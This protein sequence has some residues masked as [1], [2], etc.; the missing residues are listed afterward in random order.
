MPRPAGSGLYLEQARPQN[1]KTFAGSGKGL[2]RNVWFV[3]STTGD[4]SR[5]DGRAVVAVSL[6]KLLPFG[7]CPGSCTRT[8]KLY[9]PLHETQYG[10]FSWPLRLVIPVIIFC[11]MYQKS[12]ASPLSNI[13]VIAARAQHNETPGAGGAAGE[14]RF[15]L[16]WS[17]QW[18]YFQFNFCPR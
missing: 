6:P 3:A 18:I 11:L 12:E 8:G 16:R 10:R 15:F 7:G 1:K 5:I 4:L 17:Q 9:P 2:A 14:R 13:T